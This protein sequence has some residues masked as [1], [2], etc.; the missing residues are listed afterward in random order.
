MLLAVDV[1]NT[2]THVGLFR[3]EELLEHWRF[4][5]SRTATAEQPDVGLRVADVDR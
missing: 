2:Q 4:H 3:G 1:G 5:T